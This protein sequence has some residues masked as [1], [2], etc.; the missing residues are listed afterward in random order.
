MLNEKIKNL[1]LD[2]NLTQAE[3][4]KNINI[5]RSALS[6]YE[7]GKR[8]PD[9]ETLIKIANYFDVSTDYLL[10]NSKPSMKKEEQDIFNKFKDTLQELGLY[11][12][13]GLEKLKLA[14]KLVD[15]IKKD[16]KN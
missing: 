5:T 16:E 3:L 9:A 14:I 8:Q 4:A 7:L 13:E 1:R 12:E 15:A 10:G 2:A 11:N 6:L